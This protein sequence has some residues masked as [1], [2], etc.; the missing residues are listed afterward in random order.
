M[1]HIK[2]Q[3]SQYLNQS[4]NKP[5]NYDYDQDF[6]WLCFGWPLNSCYLIS[7]AMW[8]MGAINHTKYYFSWKQLFPM[9]MLKITEWINKNDVAT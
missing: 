5:A 8:S 7:K 6:D 4:V 3:V 2:L 1:L 9:S